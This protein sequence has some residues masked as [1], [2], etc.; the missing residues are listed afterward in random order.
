MSWDSYLDNLV[1]QSKDASGTAHVD[2]CCII[3]LDGGA[4]WTTA[5]SPFAFQVCLLL[6]PGKLCIIIYN[7]LVC[8]FFQLQGQEGA[9]IARCFKSKDFTSFM[10]N[11][12]KATGEKYQFLREEDNKIV[13]AKKKG[14]GAIT[15]QCSKTAIV[16]GHCPEGSQQ[17][18]TNK[19][20]AVIAEYLDSLGM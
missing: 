13:Y 18:N 6:K 19:A 1:A 5:A 2:K 11:G 20:V 9:N 8:S 7:Y 4:P 14:Q 3:G 10:S 15:M 16:I 12:V 17:G